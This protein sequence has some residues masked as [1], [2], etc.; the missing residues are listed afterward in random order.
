MLGELLGVPEKKGRTAVRL[1]ALVFSVSAA[2]APLKAAQSALFLA[3][4]SAE[5]LPWAFAVSAFCLASSSALSV[6]L[7][8]RLGPV[9]LANLT[10]LGFGAVFP[11]LWL[12]QDLHPSMP[13]LTYVAV[14]VCLGLLIIHTWSVVS[15]A[16]NARSAK[17]LLPLAGVGSS[18]AWVLGGAVVPLLVP[19]VGEGGLLLVAPASFL[20]AMLALRAIVRRDLV[21]GVARG[22]SGTGLFEGWRR[23]LHFVRATPLMRLIAL[24][25]LLA[26]GGEQFMDLQLLHAVERALAP[27]H[28]AGF[29]GLYYAATSL[30]GLLMSL[31][32]TGRLLE[33]LGSSR[34]LLATPLWML[35]G[36]ALV[37]MVPGLAAATALRGGY[38]ILKQGLWSSSLV[39]VQVPLPVV[40]RA[41][42]R[43]LVR[44]VIAPM[45][46]AGCALLVAAMEGL[47]LPWLGGATLGLG[48]AMG[49]LVASR[50]RSTYA[51]ALESSVD[52]RKLVLQDKP[53]R[54]QLGAVTVHQLEQQ[55]RSGPTLQAGLAVELLGGSNEP[56]AFRSVSAATRHRSAKVRLAAVRQLAR[57]GRST[58]APVL[59]HLLNRD[60]HP[61][62]RQACARALAGLGGPAQGPA[63]ER[64]LEDEDEGV[65]AWVRVARTA[66]AHEPADALLTHPHAVVREAAVLGLAT[67]V[68]QLRERLEDPSRRVRAAAVRAALRHPELLPRTLKALEDPS[69]VPAVEQVLP[70]LSPHLVRQLSE[71]VDRA[72]PRAVRNLALACRGLRG[73]AQELLLEL[74]EHPHPAVREETT[75]ALGAAVRDP[76]VRLPLARL[77]PLQD[78]ELSMAWG[79]VA[80]LGGLAHDDGRPDW[81]VQPPF[82]LLA[83]E[84]DYLL[85]ACRKRLL[86]L[87]ALSGSHRLVGA[88]ELG[89]RERTDDPQIAE[90]IE[91]SLS[92]SRGRHVVP[93]FAPQTLKERF[94]KGI[95]LGRIGAAAFEDPLGEVKKLG[96]SA[97]IGVAMVVYADRFQTRY[98]ALWEEALHA[99]TQR[100]LFLREVP[101]FRA[102]AVDDLHQVAGVLE[103]RAV[104]AGAIVL[105]KGDPGDEMLIIVSGE[106]RI[107]TDGT[108]LA[109]LGPKEF[110]GELSVIDHEPRAADAVALTDLSLLALKAADLDELMAHRPSIQDAIVR[111]LARRLRASSRRVAER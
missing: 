11:L 41:Q 89:L 105:K 73:S 79:L 13:F 3:A 78:R 95:K 6:G 87:L 60:S 111:E 67:T 69:L 5:Q 50:L 21:G 32:L 12:L 36:G 33:R 57:L 46:Y 88:Y 39:Q 91:V 42:A 62:V 23:G 35:L 59:A 2:F 82:D 30:V 97:L 49:L 86:C 64:A 77:R 101:L 24:L 31:L 18:L 28:I 83:R 90:L 22:R 92:R 81:V 76:D 66:I 19:I 29:F 72:S 52:P 103:E 10:L 51:Q 20:A 14:E 25:S 15:E 43:A 68:E 108:E 55:L 38:R 96:H 93:L 53:Q 47:S 65:R 104:A 27:E 56:S 102:L 61:Q 16:T 45:G 48:L 99:R 34:T 84:V 8:A 106:V 63:L 100:L 1:V 17:R 94:E 85:E 40:R 26:L 110:F 4:F 80:I 7:G 58:G 74:L 98:P 9:R 107:I 54:L 70:T 71:R 37:I 44:G 109:R 75:R